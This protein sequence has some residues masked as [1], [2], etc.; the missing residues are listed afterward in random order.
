MHFVI[1]K[2]IF[3]PIFIILC[4]I[5]TEIKRSKIDDPHVLYSK[6]RYAYGRHRDGCIRCSLVP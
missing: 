6:Y 1:S 4:L 5:P 3:L 2:L